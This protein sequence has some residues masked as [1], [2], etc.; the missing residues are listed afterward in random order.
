VPDAYPRPP[1]PLKI[2]LTPLPHPA[3]NTREKH[4]RIICYNRAWTNYL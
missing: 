2:E 1:P 3:Q 4:S